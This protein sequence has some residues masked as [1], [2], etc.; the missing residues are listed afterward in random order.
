MQFA[1]FG[2]IRM[3]YESHMTGPTSM[4]EGLSNSVHEHKVLRG[5][6]IPQRAGEELDKLS[7]TFFFDESFCDPEVERQRLKSEHRSGVAKPFVTGDG[8][9]DGKHFWITSLSN[10]IQKT[11][12]SGRIVRFEAQISLLEVPKSA[13]QFR[14]A[15]IANVAR[16]IFNPLLKRG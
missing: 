5:K 4:S 7:F 6:P 11:T 14:G 1:T 10:G 3:G 12:P 16:A 9:Y 2:D 8:G 15:G 13:G